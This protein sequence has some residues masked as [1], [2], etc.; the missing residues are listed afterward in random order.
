MLQ[1]LQYMSVKKLLISSFILLAVDLFLATS[2]ARLDD[3]VITHLNGDVALRSDI[4]SAIVMSMC[5]AFPLLCLFI[6]SL[7][8]L[9]VY[10][11]LPYRKR[12][13]KAFLFTFIFFYTLI[14]ISSVIKLLMIVTK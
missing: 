10:K 12:F 9:F 7:L 6:A 2:V 1:T 3:S 13:L 11:S 8:A 14:A 4:I 5:I